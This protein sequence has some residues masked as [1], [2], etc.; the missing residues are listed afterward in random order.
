MSPTT[1]SGE[2]EERFDP[3]L[4][5]PSLADKVAKTITEAIENWRTS[6]GYLGP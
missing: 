2:S 3:V 6:S 1:S 5:D 4:R